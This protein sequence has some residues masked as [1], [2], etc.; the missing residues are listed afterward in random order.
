MRRLERTVLA[1][2]WAL[3]AM[4]LIVCVAAPAEFRA[5]LKAAELS[6]SSPSLGEQ[7]V[8]RGG[9]RGAASSARRGS[10]AESLLDSNAADLHVVAE[11]LRRAQVDLA[12]ATAIASRHVLEKAGM[13]ASVEANTVL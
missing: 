9:S 12:G 11:V 7:T 4:R 6:P 3:E 8:G 13:K 2:L 10:R 1:R 5:H